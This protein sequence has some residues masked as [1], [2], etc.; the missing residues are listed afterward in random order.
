MAEEKA[1]QLTKKG[2]EELKAKHLELIKKRSEIA[3]RL[4]EARKQG[5]LSE[6]SEYDEAKESQTNN[7]REIRNI[8]AILKNYELIDESALTTD[9]V[10]MGQKVVLMD[11]ELEEEEE[12]YIVGSTEADPMHGKISNESPIGKAIIGKKAGETVTV[13][14]PSGAFD[15]KIIE[16]KA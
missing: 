2:L 15:Y 8:E 5:D 10:H 14:T 13:E 6:N 16:I 11:V 12:Y 1:K 4:D 3:E 9:T 7:E